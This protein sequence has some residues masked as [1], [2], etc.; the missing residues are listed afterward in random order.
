[1]IRIFRQYISPRKALFL[2]G[3]GVLIFF[4]VSIGTYLVLERW[5]DFGHMLYVQWPKILLVTVVTQMSLYLNDLYEFK[6]DESRI[7]LYSRLIR[8]IGIT[9]IVLSVIYFIWPRVMIGRWIFFVSIIFL[10]LFL[11]SWRILYNLTINRRLLSEKAILVGDGELA[12]DLINETKH[13]RD[14]SYDIRAIVGLKNGGNP[15]NQFENIPVRYGFK[16][17]C[18]FA[19]VNG[20]SSI[21]VALDEKR[22]IMPYK[23]LLDCKVRGLS[24]IDGASF[25]ERITGK[26]LA[27]KINPSWL[28]FSDGFRKSRTTKIF[29][30]LFDL[31]MATLMLILLSPLMLVVTLC[32]KLESP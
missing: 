4:A 15:Q 2:I 30:R 27:E 12:K 19:T 3:E 32:I 17:L 1:M 16:D 18:A 6:K 23:E 20:I 31:I 11:I 25:Y 8:S 7:D 22:Q 29:K 21:I 28:V 13:Q 24:I 14:F 9:C 10:V 5:I 26:L